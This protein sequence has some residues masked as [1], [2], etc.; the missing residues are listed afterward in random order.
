MTVDGD[1][2]QSACP[3]VSVSGHYAAGISEIGLVAALAPVLDALPPGDAGEKHLA[4]L[5][6]FH[7]RGPAASAELAEMAGVTSGERVLDAGSGLGG[8]SRFLARTLNCQV[9]GIDI[10]PDFVALAAHLAARAGLSADVQYEVGDISR[11][12]IADASFDLVW[13][14]HVLM[15]LRDREAPYREFHR[16][17]RPGGRFAFYEPIAVEGQAPHYPL[18]WASAAEQSYLLTNDQIVSALERSGFSL[19]EWRDVS[20]AAVSSF[21]PVQEPPPVAGLAMVMGPRFPEMAMNFAKS[22]AD[23]R[24]KLIMG[25]AERL[26]Q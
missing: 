11:L 9:V 21:P 16:I 20:T 25:V 6:H 3:T 8:P 12:S 14:E 4:A 23:G 18:P 19:R 24:L 2:G 15:N 26:P 1:S 5:D 22:I 13:S 10:T 17:L 7:V